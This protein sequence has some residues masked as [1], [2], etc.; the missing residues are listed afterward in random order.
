[1]DSFPAWLSRALCCLNKSWR[2]YEREVKLVRLGFRSFEDPKT[3]QESEARGR[4]SQTKLPEDTKSAEPF[5]CIPRA[6]A[7]I[8]SERVHPGRDA[9]S[10]A[11]IGLTPAQLMVGAS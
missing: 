2:E 5:K 11:G 1:M 6:Q 7:R 8:F 3:F 10:S 9:Q 4:R